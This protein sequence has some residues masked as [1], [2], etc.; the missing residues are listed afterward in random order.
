MP[1]EKGDPRNLTA[2][3]GAH[4]RSPAWSPDG[5]RS[6]TSP[7][8]AASTRCTSPGRRQGRGEAYKL[9]GRR[10]LRRP[11]AGRRTARRSPTST[12]R[13]RCICIDLENRQVKKV[14]VGQR[15]GPPNLVTLRP[16][17]RR[18]RSGSPTR[19]GNK[20][21]YH[22][23]SLYSVAQDKSHPLTDGLERRPEPVF[24][25]AASTSTSS[26]RPTPARA[27]LVRPVERRQSRAR[28]TCTW[29]CCTRACR[30]RWPRRATRRKPQPRPEAGD[31]T[32]SRGEDEARAP[33][34]AEPVA[35]DFDG[36]DTASSPCRCRPATLAICRPAPPDSLYLPAP[37]AGAD[38]ALHR[39]DLH[40]SARTRRSSTT[41]R[42]SPLGR[43]QGAALSRRRHLVDRADGRRSRAR[44]GQAQRGGGR[45]A[46]S[47]RAPS[48]RRSS[49]R[50]GASTAI[51]STTRTCTAATGRR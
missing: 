39:F 35:I 4:E 44:Q 51:T 13:S 28:A 36:I 25:A 20:A 40:A 38:Q 27:R 22:A 37:P 1:A 47:S 7:T 26:P 46:A 21:A 45:G 2:T 29:S 8:R 14:R 32:R 19:L 11:P 42:L 49:T 18:T 33:R 48:G 24:D 9:D 31:K 6:P 41:S 30:R 16:P 50:P 5:K 15:Y 43:R 17:G 3:P 34:Q 10:L 12:T 23:V